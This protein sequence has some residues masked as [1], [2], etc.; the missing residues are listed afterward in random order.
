MHRD[1]QIGL[2][3]SIV[4]IGFAA[5]LC[6]PRQAQRTGDRS[7]QLEAAELDAE[8][9]QLPVRP[10]VSQDR[11]ARSLPGESD[12]SHGT[13]RSGPPKDPAPGTN[14][15]AADG[16]LPGDDSGEESELLQPPS[17]GATN[18]LADVTPKVSPVEPTPEERSSE[19]STLTAKIDDAQ[20]TIHVV[21]AGDTLSG[22]AQ[23]YLG[24]V[25]R[26][27]EIFEANRDQLETPDDLQLN[28][29]LRIPTGR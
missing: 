22:L 12:A 8:I 17:I 15:Q 2:A 5:A 29:R 18:A 10:Y 23:R 7:Q 9:E 21:R 27:P 20:T 19:T 1:T 25:A 28:M 24:S 6:F 16:G 14:L 13:G 26:Y 11:P 3:M 4:L